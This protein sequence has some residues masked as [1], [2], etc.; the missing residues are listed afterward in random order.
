MGGTDLL[1]EGIFLAPYSLETL[2]YFNWAPCQPDN[3]HQNQHCVS[4]SK[5]DALLRWDDDSCV[6]NNWPLCQRCA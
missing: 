1:Q 5:N 6:V 2:T 4:I 3:F